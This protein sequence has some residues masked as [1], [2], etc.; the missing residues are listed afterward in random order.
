MSVPK[1]VI[2]ELNRLENLAAEA[3]EFTTQGR[4]YT[5]QRDALATQWAN[6]SRGY[7][8]RLRSASPTPATN[9]P[10][11]NVTGD[12]A[13]A[14]IQS[15]DRYIQRD[16]ISPRQRSDA[17]NRRT[18]IQNQALEASR[19]QRQN[20][21]QQV[22]SRSNHTPPSK[23]GPL[24]S[25]HQFINPKTRP[26]PSRGYPGAGSNL[27]NGA[28]A[29]NGLNKV[30][31]ALGVV[32]GA[33]NAPG[34]FRQGY[35]EGFNRGRYVPGLSEASGVAQGLQNTLT[36]FSPSASAAG[37]LTGLATGA[38]NRLFGKNKPDSERA[39]EITQDRQL[40]SGITIPTNENGDP[41]AQEPGRVYDISF[42]G[43]SCRPKEG[44]CGNWS[45]GERR[46]VGPVR[47]KIERNEQQTPNPDGSP[48]YGKTVKVI[49]GNPEDDFNIRGSTNED[50]FDPEGEITDST[51]VDG[52]PDNYTPNLPSAPKILA[53]RSTPY[54]SPGTGPQDSSAPEPT[55]NATPQDIASPT[56]P[57]PSQ[58]LSP[59]VAPDSG[60]NEAPTAPSVPGFPPL[61]L[62]P[63]NATNA[64]NNRKPETQ[65][66]NNGNSSNPPDSCN[67]RCGLPGINQTKKTEKRIL[68]ALGNLTDLSGLGLLVTILDIVNGISSAVGVSA[69]PMSVPSILNKKSTETTTLNNLGEAHLWQAKNL[70][71]TIGGWPNTIQD[72]DSG[73]PLENLTV[74]DSLAEIQGMLM[75]MAVGQGI[76]QQGI[77][78]TLTETTGIKQQTMLARQFAQGNAEYLGYN[79]RQTTRQVP[80]TYTPGVEN[81]LELLNPGHVPMEAVENVDNMDLQSCLRELC[82]SAAIIRAVF[83]RNTGTNDIEQALRERLD[84]AR[85]VNETAGGSDFDEYLRQVEQG[86]GL[87][88]PYGRD[89]TQGPQ[90]RDRSDNTTP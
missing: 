52:L 22:T 32:Y 25:S 7:T 69:F 80:N 74:S 89:Q 49:T 46:V 16:D 2:S 3:G 24:T 5:A 79:L 58:G 15:I 63:G 83:F 39:P 66:G 57:S 54:E 71:S 23:G 26:T 29:L 41:I 35:A 51:P 70:D 86:F 10:K 81:I 40:P 72:L 27:G 13:L 36:P 34:N 28:R 75:A 47:I 88:N 8:D 12:T 44:T 33:V 17:F 9:G 38:V 11:L 1:E 85:N 6:R 73:N 78:K 65:S 20:L 76:N 87:S 55:P 60:R 19:V 56:I 68:D 21:Q 67:S 61:P 84:Q 64:S 53:P 43:R 90:L 18:A 59:G 77:F 30:S 14:Q 42:R 31:N 82:A 48:I 4:S 45:E 62:I 37:F 50:V